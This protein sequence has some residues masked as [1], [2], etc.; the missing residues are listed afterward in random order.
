MTRLKYRV[1]WGYKNEHEAGFQTLE[2]AI[3]FGREGLK[4][5]RHRNEQPPTITTDE[6]E[7]DYDWDE[8]RFKRFRGLT[9]EE[10]DRV[11]EE[12]LW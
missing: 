5:P 3:A 9:R 8:G 6:E 2:E 1:Q 11:I 4:M 12:D 10:E 7:W